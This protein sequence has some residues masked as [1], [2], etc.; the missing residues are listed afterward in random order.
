MCIKYIKYLKMY[1]PNNTSTSFKVPHSGDFYELEFI[2]KYSFLSSVFTIFCYCY[3]L[4]LYT[5][6]IISMI[7]TGYFPMVLCFLAIDMID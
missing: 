4:Y 3:F 5:L 2:F 1:T 6:L 7:K